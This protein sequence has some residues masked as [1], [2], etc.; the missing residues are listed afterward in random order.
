MNLN[1]VLVEL[2]NPAF[3]AMEKSKEECEAKVR[4]YNRLLRT[5]EPSAMTPST[6][7]EARQDDRDKLRSALD[8]MVDTIEKLSLKHGQ[9]LGSQE[10][11]VWKQRITEGESEYFNYINTVSSKLEPPQHS[12]P[13]PVN[14]SMPGAAA[15]AATDQSHAVNNAIADVKVDAEIVAAEGKQLAAKVNK[16]LDWSEATNEEIE[17]AMA[18]V[19]GWEKKFAKIQEKGY[20]V[21]RNTLKFN[22][23]DMELRRVDAV[24]ANLEAEIDIAVDEITSEDKNRCLFSLS[25]SKAADVK[26]PG[27]SGNKEEDFSKFRKEFEKGLKTNRVRKEDQVKKLRECLKDDAKMIIPDSM[28][29]IYAAWD[30]LKNMYGDASRVMEA[31][32]R[33]IKDM[34]AYPRTGKNDVLL[35][36]QIE[37]ITKLEVTLNDIKELAEESIQMERDAY[38]SDMVHLIMSYFPNA[39]QKNLQEE[40]EGLPDDG[41][42]KL[43]KIQD[44]MV[45]HRRIVQGLLKTAE[46]TA[47]QTPVEDKIRGSGSNYQGNRGGQSFRR[48]QVGDGDKSKNNLD[49]RGY[50]SRMTPKSAM[51]FRPSQ[52]DE[53]CRVCNALEAMGDTKD[54]YD[55]HSN[56]VAVG[57]PRFATMTMEKKRDIVKKAQLCDYCLDQ[58]AVVKPGTLHAMCPVLTQKRFYSC[59]KEGCKTHYWLCDS[60]DHILMNKK[61]AELAKKYWNNRGITFVHLAHFFR[62]EL[63]GVD[64][65]VAAESSKPE[66]D[67]LHHG[68]GGG[69]GGGVL[70]PTGNLP[71]SPTKVCH[72]LSFPLDVG[73]REVMKEEV[74]MYNDSLGGVPVATKVTVMD[75]EEHRESH[76]YESALLEEIGY[77]DP[78]SG[79][80]VDSRADVP[81]DS[82]DGTHDVPCDTVLTAVVTDVKRKVETEDNPLPGLQHLTF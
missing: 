68:G 76:T 81:Y 18:A 79:L 82:Q 29:D 64:G 41:R 6:L 80:I 28:E 4:K 65:G 42:T 2:S 67:V 75:E 35:K 11:A 15:T 63:G 22:L 24:M 49:N 37:W 43:F 30:I 9:E 39:I 19:E 34:G 23:D 57:C 61:K 54:L 3:E 45:K 44:Y 10:V 48:S 50:V 16:Y 12:A 17:L 53:K 55:D 71:T 25:R 72:D 62:A 20:A 21:K 26:L 73:V 59:L 74:Y 5:C 46:A 1:T 70:E 13:R 77:P 36:N 69:G 38:G 47:S 14:V 8:E 31:R 56:S 58:H 52:R 51:L 7:Q 60:P 27:F 33:K 66:N 78:R 32:K 40:M